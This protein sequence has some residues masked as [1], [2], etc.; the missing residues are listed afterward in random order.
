MPLEECR[1]CLQAVQPGRRPKQP[2]ALPLVELELKLALALELA[3]APPP[4]L[5]PF[6]RWGS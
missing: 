4:L 1:S 5:G 6:D 3:P 2:L